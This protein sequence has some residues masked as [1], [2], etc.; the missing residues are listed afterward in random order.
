MHILLHPPPSPL[1][2]TYFIFLS[3]ILQIDQ[4]LSDTWKKSRLDKMPGYTHRAAAQ[5]HNN[6]S[7][8]KYVASLLVLIIVFGFVY[9]YPWHKP[10]ISEARWR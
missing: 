1:F 4:T 6:Q 2:P 8:G 9:H 3:L 5:I 7:Y 10:S